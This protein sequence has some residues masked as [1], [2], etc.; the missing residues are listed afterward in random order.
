MPPVFPLGNQTITILRAE[1]VTNPRDNSDDLDW[2]N[3]SAVVV[4]A[5]NVQPFQDG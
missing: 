3:A 2:D 1:Y 5:C 4:A